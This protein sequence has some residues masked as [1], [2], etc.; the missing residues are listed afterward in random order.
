MC[1]CQIIKLYILNLHNVICQLYSNK[2]R[3]KS[4]A[5]VNSKYVFKR[6]DIAGEAEE[7]EIPEE[8]WPVSIYQPPS[9]NG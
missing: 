7:G 6:L 5:C 2:T 4:F 1:V 9:D 8:S 3:K